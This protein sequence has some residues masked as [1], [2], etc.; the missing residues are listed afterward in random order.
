MYEKEPADTAPYYSEP[1]L[2][3]PATNSAHVHPSSILQPASHP[4]PVMVLPS[5]HPSNQGLILAHIKA[6]LERSF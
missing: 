5:S 6:Q 2:V 1:A 4:S 3:V